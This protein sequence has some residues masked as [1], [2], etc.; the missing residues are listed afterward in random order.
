MISPQTYETPVAL[1]LLVQLLFVLKWMYRRTRDGQVE[2][3]FVRDMAT[4]HLPHIYDAQLK[5]CAKLGIELGIP[6]PIR[7]M[8]FDDREK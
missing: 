6:P 1:A 5:I 2:R 3:K 4:N 7:W 8:D